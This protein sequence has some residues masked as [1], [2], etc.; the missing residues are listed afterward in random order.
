MY[1]LLFLLA[2][3]QQVCCHPDHGSHPGHSNGTSE[4]IES[5]NTETDSF[6]DNDVYNESDDDSDYDDSFSDD[7]EYNDYTDYNEDDL[8]S[9]RSKLKKEEHLHK[10]HHLDVNKG[11]GKMG[12]I[13]HINIDVNIG[14][15]SPEDEDNGSHDHHDHH[16]DHDHKS[17]HE[18]EPDH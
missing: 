14:N 3:L 17:H 12:Q 6:Y 5:N 18:H 1:L 11:H 13:N 2:L 7:D 4:R 10:L 15:N 9:L 8:E 16:F